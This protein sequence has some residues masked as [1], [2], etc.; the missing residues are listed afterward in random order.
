MTDLAMSKYAL[1]ISIET[2]SDQSAYLGQ[3]GHFL[4]VTWVNG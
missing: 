1:D 4:W 3:M 2:G